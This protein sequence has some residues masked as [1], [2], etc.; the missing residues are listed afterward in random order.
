MTGEMGNLTMKVDVKEN[1]ME[2]LMMVN[3]ELLEV[4]VSSG[5]AN[6]ISCKANG[7][8]QVASRLL[9]LG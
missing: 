5:E 7:V 4:W 8:I 3:T 9:G 2:G 6:S 1:M